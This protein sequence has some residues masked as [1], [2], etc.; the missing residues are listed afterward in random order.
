MAFTAS[1]KNTIIKKLRDF[2]FHDF[3]SCRRTNLPSTQTTMNKNAFKML[4]IMME[5]KPFSELQVMYGG[6]REKKGGGRMTLGIPKVTGRSLKCLLLFFYYYETSLGNV[7][8]Y[9]LIISAF[10]S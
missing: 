5:E 10:P 9:G 3:F 1:L 8:I 2:T 6:R 7:Q 4:V